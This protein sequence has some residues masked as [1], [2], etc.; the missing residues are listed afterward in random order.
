MS[1]SNTSDH[2]RAPVLMAPLDSAIAPHVEPELS[3]H[4]Q[5]AV[6]QRQFHEP[7]IT[8]AHQVLA[9]SLDE[10]AFSGSRM[11]GAATQRN[12]EQ[13]SSFHAFSRRLEPG[14]PRSAMQQPRQSILRPY[15]LD[16]GYRWHIVLML[17]AIAVNSASSN[18]QGILDKYSTWCGDNVCEARTEQFG[19]CPNDC[20]CGDGVCDDSEAVAASC[21]TDCLSHIEIGQQPSSTSQASVAFYNQPVIRILSPTQSDAYTPGKQILFGM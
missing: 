19:W 18:P 5:D 1:R 16:W 3:H 2:G 12:R 11:A 9:S 15:L 13:S 17:L 21:P 10:R 20:F 6:A 8:V 14:N 4:C 7:L